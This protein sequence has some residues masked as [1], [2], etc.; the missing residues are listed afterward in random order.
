[1][2]REL[3]LSPCQSALRIR[4]N[5]LLPSLGKHLVKNLC[6]MATIN[7]LIHGDILTVVHYFPLMATIL[8]TTIDQ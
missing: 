3:G 6:I 4:Y 1:M 2:G 8:L 5:I 7:D